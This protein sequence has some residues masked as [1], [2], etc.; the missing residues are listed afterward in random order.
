M[1]PPDLQ[2]KPMTRGKPAASKGW[3]DPPLVGSIHCPLYRYI[4]LTWLVP[5]TF[6]IPLRA[7]YLIWHFPIKLPNVRPYACQ[8]KQRSQISLIG[9]ETHSFQCDLTL[10]RFTP[11]ILASWKRFAVKC[12]PYRDIRCDFL[13]LATPKDCAHC[14]EEAFFQHR[15]FYVRMHMVP[16]KAQTSP[17]SPAGGFFEPCLQLYIITTLIL[18]F[19]VY[20]FVP[21]LLAL[22]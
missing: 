9:S 6:Q 2:N 19:D 21:A 1:F 8:D 11:L 13:H 14:C 5:T 17:C 20:K 22:Q 12:H 7:Q 10:T 3:L 16:H 15:Y 4:S 18:C